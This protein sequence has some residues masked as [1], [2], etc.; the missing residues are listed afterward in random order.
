ME[1]V[2]EKDLFKKILSKLKDNHE[3]F[4]MQHKNSNVLIID[5][6]NS[7]MR[8]FAADTT[9]NDNGE[10]IG[11]VSGFL[12]T[13]GYAIKKFSPTRCIIVFDGQ[14]GSRRR[15]K[16]YKEYK[17]GRKPISMQK[18]NR[19]L[20]LESVDN[21]KLLVQQASRLAEYL[22]C[23]PITVMQIDDIEADDVIAYLVKQHFTKESESTIVM[24]TD[25]DFLQLVDTTTR[26]WS[27][28]KKI[29]YDV[30][31]VLEEY[32]VHPKN[33]INYRIIEGDDSDNITGIKH[34]GKKTIAKMFGDLL[35]KDEEVEIA[36]LLEISKEKVKTLK[37]YQRIV[38]NEDIL[39]RNYRLMQLQ[40]VDISLQKKTE[41]LANVN[42]D[43]PT[44]D[45]IQFRKLFL[46]DR[47]WAT[48][49][50]I[51][52]WLNEVFLRMNTLASTK[53]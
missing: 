29:V 50:S 52:S 30:D 24:S 22:A 9:M 38:E 42:R 45:R 7:F 32:E 12:K 27:P 34:I 53:N 13:I 2:N 26:V 11:A 25:K 35:M 43:I 20:E 14:N 40:E 18:Y 49:K 6:T 47:M 39:E 21:E 4:K 19:N 8:A 17:A 33:M 51:D 37:S 46:E 31:K 23:L 28:T 15:R 48:F 16:L 44:I 41:I 5:G 36:T 3:E 1:E 10:Y